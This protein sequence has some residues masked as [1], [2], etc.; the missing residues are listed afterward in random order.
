MK[1]L[2]STLLTLFIFSILFAQ[3]KPGIKG[4]T[5]SGIKGIQK[6]LGQVIAQERAIPPNLKVHLRPE[7]EG[8]KPK[9]QDPNAKPVSKFGT[10]VTN[11]NT[12]YKTTLTS[13][14]TQAV[15][16]NFLTIW[17]NYGT[18]VS[19]RESPYT[20]PDNCGD[21]GTTQI[22]ATANCRMKVFNKPSLNA[23][24]S[25]PTGSSTTTLT[26]VVNVDLNT[27][28]TVSAIGVN[29]I[30]D[31]HVRFDRLSGRWFIVAIDVNH[32]SGSNYCLV[33]VSDGPTIT[34]STNF[35]IFYFSVAGTG[36][37]SNDFFD[38]PTL[39]VDKN[40]LYIGGNMFANGQR[41]S[42]CNLWVVNKASLLSG[43]PMTVTSFPHGVTNTNMYTPQG[44]H[45]DDP[46]ATEGYF[47]G[48]SQT[49]YSRLNI[50]R[51]SYSGGTPTLSAD[52]PL[53][54]SNTYTPKTVPTL[55]GTAIDGNDRR[56]CAA[57]IKKNKITGVANLWI[58]Q[59]TLLNSAGVYVSGA[60]RDGALWMEIGNLKTTPTILQ[61]ATLYDDVNPT[62][63]AVYYTYPTIALSGQGHN[64]MG[65]T[66]AGPTKYAQASAAGRYRTDPA[67]N[68]QSPVDFTNTT[69]SYNPGANRW[70]DYT[71][72][73]V[74]PTDDMTMWTFSE[75]AATTNA[76]GVRAAQFKAPPPA[77]P[78]LASTPACGA[79]TTV[80]INATHGS[81]PNSEFFDP[82]DD[83]AA[84]GP[85]FN[86]LK[87][88]VSGPSA[89]TVANVVFV[90]P[91]QI[92]ANF[93][94]PVNAVSGTY[95]VT[96]TNPDGQ[97][98]TTTF[99]LSCA[100]AT[101]GDPTNLSSSSID[102]T[103]ENVSWTAVSGANSYDVDYKLTTSSTWTNAAT[104]TTSTSVNIT[105]LTQGTL[106]D[107]RVRAN[108]TGASGNYVAAQFTTTAPP[109]TCDVPANLSA[110]SITSSS[111][112]VSW[113]AVSGAVSYD[114]DYKLSSSG[115]W[116]NA[117]TATTLTSI[118][119]SGLDPSAQYDWQVRSNCSSSLSSGYSTSQ[120]TTT[121]PA[122]TCDAPTGL[123]SSAI[124]S[125][126]ATVSWSAVSGA[127]SYDVDYAVHNSG[128]WTNVA[129]GT[130]STSAN[131]TGLTASTNYDWRVRTNCSSV[132]SGYSTGQFS[133]I[134]DPNTC[135]DNYESN[136]TSA[137]AATIAANSTITA[138]IAPAGDQD[139]FSFSTSG[140]QKNFKVTLSNLPANYILKVYDSKGIQLPGSDLSVAYNTNKAGTYKILVSGA[141]GTE[142]SSAQCYTLNVQTGSGTFSATIAD[143]SGNNIGL[144]KGGALKLYPVPA[145][146][147]VTISFD[148]YAKGSADVV[149]INQLGQQV[150]YKKV[151]TGE[152]IN[153]N[154]IDVSALKAGIYTL[155]VNNG[156]EIQ[157]K[158]MIISR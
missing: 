114:V 20:P 27:F 128:S 149:I 104:A 75:Y 96:I 28:F 142:T 7:L 126:G 22:I 4:I 146:N 33:A 52:I 111:A 10:L 59:G 136:N 14:P 64:I 94:V 155:K 39:G 97:T 31:P 40:S 73:V 110:T 120:F 152:G 141:T 91:L 35:K 86:R 115:T 8:P 134:A 69:S 151:L 15:V 147:A 24:V 30:S 131:I 121:A 81:N 85:G 87:V 76:W 61:S 101:C 88:D 34:A 99:N 55:G 109:P 2:L 29:S 45:N 129:T 132:S 102:N 37:A 116:I 92:T 137:T 41:F 36:G 83:V 122:P 95:T 71:Q 21:V 53:T 112:T 84:G 108:C 49:V 153:F 43:G 100:A 19:G 5:I 17:G 98:S 58:A 13:A 80:T 158:K 66:S 57:M 62:S 130:T 47:V 89:I 77:N 60:D 107:W 138:T 70:G 78:S 68:F 42:G 93:N 103:N 125:S 82:G 18:A 50:K 74:D 1:K 127:N 3:N 46:G 11:N 56:L 133:T 9:G 32:T 25:T 54:T 38:Y 135:P 145:T 157:T 23:P 12:T 16:S 148:A 79:I 154:T 139:Y 150:L 63:S 65:F 113:S 144:V 140:S 72:T 48:A 106:Y 6:S 118:T 124:T 123:A 156:K 51:V 119:L 117:A 26:S 90:N 143:E 44:V 67:G 105:G